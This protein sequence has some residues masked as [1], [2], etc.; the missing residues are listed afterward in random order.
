MRIVLSF[1]FCCAIT[2]S[3]IA[4]QNTFLDRDFWKAKPS[5]EQVQ[6]LQKAGNDL[7]ALNS[8]GFDAT[9][10]AI[11]EN[12]STNVITY[13]LEQPGNGMEKRTHDS[14]TYVFWAAYKGNIDIMDY[15]LKNGAV[16]KGIHD[17]NGNTPVTFAASTGQVDSAVYD[18]FEQHGV[19]LKEEQNESGVNLLQLV[20]P[21]LKTEEQLNY[22]LKKGFDL[23]AIDP[24][25]NTIILHAAKGGHISFL[26]TLV[27]K[28]IDPK[29]TNKNGSNAMLYASMG[30]RGASYDLAVFKY[31]E[32]LG[33]NPKVVGD[34]GRNP[35]HRIAHRSNDVSLFKY[36]LEKG[37]DL[38]LQDDG[39]D[40]PFMNIAN[41]ADLV[42]MEYVY[43]FANAKYINH[44]DNTGKTALAMAVNRNNAAMVSFLLNKN[45]DIT[46]VDNNGNNLGYYLLNSYR[47]NAV[48][49]FTAKLALLKGSGL[50]FKATQHDGNSLLHIAVKKNDLNL[51]KYASDFNI[52]VNAKNDEGYTALHLAAMKA[53]DDR[54]LKY[55][56]SF[57]ADKTIATDFEETAYDLASEN[58]L[59]QQHNINLNFLH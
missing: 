34:S 25:G 24:D 10:Y 3:S 54:I 15:L 43:A 48:D 17:S 30:A 44:K 37:V 45:A 57:G 1:I 38:H 42:V 31:L 18:L 33:V 58:E 40:S 2:M 12:A 55:L 41:S 47:S 16:I 5:V 28:G 14:R 8:N 22:F 29:V 53:S 50:D 6:Q 4:Q 46:V 59:L 36:F 27:K 35:L 56:L 49:E 11:L 23:G 52:D 26:E 51:V 7:T 13:L 19:N 21:Y 20:A 9:V 39:G 32:Q